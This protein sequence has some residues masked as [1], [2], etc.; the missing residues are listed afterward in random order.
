MIS[1]P[2][3]S[4]VKLADGRSSTKRFRRLIE[5]VSNPYRLLRLRL[6]CV[7]VRRR[8]HPVVLIGLLLADVDHPI[9]AE[10]VDTHA[11]DVAPHLRLQGN[12]YGSFVR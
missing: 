4:G 6:R 10:L 7:E 3:F 5:A 2:V 8:T 1:T 12:G 9:D 11:K